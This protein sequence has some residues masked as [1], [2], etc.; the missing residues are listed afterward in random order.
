MSRLDV[1]D[2]WLSTD[3]TTFRLSCNI[4]FLSLKGLF[5]KKIQFFPSFTY[6]HAVPNRLDFRSSSGTQMKIF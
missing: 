1:F 2:S 3:V 6:S 4:S 5:T